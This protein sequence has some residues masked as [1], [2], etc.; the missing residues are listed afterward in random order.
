MDFFTLFFSHV[1]NVPYYLIWLGGIVYAIVNGRKHPRTSLMAG[2]A[3]G[4]LLI[5]GLVSDIG[6]SYIRYQAFTSDLPTMLYGKKLTALT[7]CSFPFSILGWLL[8]LAA[9]FGRKN[10]LERE[11]V[12]NHAG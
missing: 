7:V 9:V 2:I 12:N 5:E 1:Y 4:I 10:V 11:T 6:S 3:L 8:L